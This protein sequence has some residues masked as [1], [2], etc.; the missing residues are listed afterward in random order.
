MADTLAAP[1]SPA[2]AAGPTVAP[3]TQFVT[4]FLTEAFRIARDDND[5]PTQRHSELAALLTRGMDMRRILQYA[6]HAAFQAASASVQQEFVTA[7]ADFLAEAYTP[8][9][10]LAAEFSFASSAPRVTPEGTIVS[11]TFTKPGYPSSTIDLQV[12]QAG[13]SYR[14]VDVSTQG[15]SLLE[16]QR[17]SFTS[18]MMNEGGLQGVLAKME[19]RTR[20]L[21]SV[22]QVSDPRLSDL[23]LS[24]APGNMQKGARCS[25]N[26]SGPGITAATSITWWPVPRPARRWRSTR[27]TTRNAWPRRRPRAGTSPRSSTPTNTATIP[28]ATTRSIARD[29]RQAARTPHAADR[30]T[31]STA[32]SRPAT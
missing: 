29:P 10:K 22:G 6:T 7:F 17:S 28:A 1:P 18:V 9:I 26:R 13:N 31:A 32:G 24:L 5:A 30:S 2:A 15:V 23:V 16:I 8:R 11:T 3:A 4:A 25:S 27:S 21:A 20:E 12:D 19:T 14:I